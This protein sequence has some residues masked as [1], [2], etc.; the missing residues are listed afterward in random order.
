MCTDILSWRQSK[1][2]GWLPQTL[3]SVDPFN[4]DSDCT[5]WLAGFEKDCI[6]FGLTKDRMLP[7][8]EL[9]HAAEVGPEVGVEVGPEYGYEYGHE[10]GHE[11]EEAEAEGEGSGER[12][13]V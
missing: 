9:E 8:V 2:L 6:L 10:H 4:K 13:G 3:K 12:S 7:S 11:G 5:A 1:D